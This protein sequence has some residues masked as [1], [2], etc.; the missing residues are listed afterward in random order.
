MLLK[1]FWCHSLSVTFAV[2]R[3]HKGS[4]YKRN[5]LIG[6]LLTVSEGQSTIIIVGTWGQ[7]LEQ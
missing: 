1:L 2:K 4:Y 3:H 6:G 5:N 7:T